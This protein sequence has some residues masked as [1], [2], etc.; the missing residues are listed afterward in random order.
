ME[1]DEYG[2]RKEMVEVALLGMDKLITRLA[3]LQNEVL[4]RTAETSLKKVAVKIRDSAKKLC[5]VATGSLQ[6]SI[7]LQVHARPARHIHKI[8][9]SAGGYIT[10]P[11]TGRRVDYARYVE[12]GTSR[13]TMH[14]FMRPALFLHRKELLH[15]AKKVIR[16]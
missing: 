9:V 16:K 1:L 15:E 2:R 12:H 5:P 13:M 14:P 7:R 8:G 4:D 11:N 10:N 3:N 6:K